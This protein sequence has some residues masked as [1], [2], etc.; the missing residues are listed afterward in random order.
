MS[1]SYAQTNNHFTTLTNITPGH[2]SSSLDTLCSTEA[3][4]LES[5]YTDTQE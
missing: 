4:F 3:W 1:E 5:E 2:E